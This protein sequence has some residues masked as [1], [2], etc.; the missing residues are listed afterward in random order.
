MA[1]RCRFIRQLSWPISHYPD[2]RL[3]LIK[4]CSKGFSQ[5]ASSTVKIINFHL[6]NMNHNYINVLGVHINL[7]CQIS[8]RTARCGIILSVCHNVFSYSVSWEGYSRDPT[9][10]EGKTV[11]IIFCWRIM[12]ERAY[13]VCQ[14]FRSPW[15]FSVKS[16]WR[17]ERRKREC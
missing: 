17:D 15:E 12:S 14:N 8:N 9:L 3:E 10:R 16:N 5:L 6:L 1:N 13:N 2:I 4:S 11:F 7:I